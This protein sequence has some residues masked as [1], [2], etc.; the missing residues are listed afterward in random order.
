[1]ADFCSMFVSKV[2]LAIKQG[3]KYFR[4]WKIVQGLVKL[5]LILFQTDPGNAHEPYLGSYI[6]W[7]DPKKALFPQN[8]LDKSHMSK[9]VTALE[10]EWL[11]IITSV[12]LI[13]EQKVRQFWKALFVIISKLSY[14]PFY[15]KKYGSYDFWKTSIKKICRQLQTKTFATT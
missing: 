9:I 12:I 1:M 2:R 10:E 13:I 7:M 15:N 3:F 5:S 11:S 6:I 14:F 8:K 4:V